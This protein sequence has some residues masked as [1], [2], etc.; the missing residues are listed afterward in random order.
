MRQILR[1]FPPLEI[2]QRLSRLLGR[3]LPNHAAV[4][5]RLRWPLWVLPA[6][7]LVQLAID[8]PVW[9]ITSVAVLLLY[10]SGWLWVR[11]LARSVRLQRTRQGTLFVAGDTLEEQWQI[12][13]DGNVPVSWAECVDES[14]LPG[15]APGRV[16]AV[17][18]NATQKWRTT[19]LCRE[20]GVFRLGPHRLHLAD[21]MRLFDLSLEFPYSESVLI[22]PR[23]VQLP[24]FPLPRGY[25]SGDQRTR[26]PLLGVLPAPTVRTYQP[27]DSLR[28]VHWPT[29]AHRG[30]L[31]VRELEQEPSGAIWVILDTAG[32]AHSREGDHSTLEVAITAAASLAAQF[33]D[34]SR[35]AV[36]I[37]T[38]SGSEG[39]AVTVAPA[40]GSAHLWRILSALAPVRAG[41]TPLDQI[42]RAA[43]ATTGARSSLVV[44]TAD[45]A[46]PERVQA[47]NAQLV[48]TAEAGNAAALLLVATNASAAAAARVRSLL[49]PWQIPVEVLPVDTPMTALLTRKRT[50]TI[51]RTT[52]QGRTL[53]LEVEEEVG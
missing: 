3:G 12:I 24:I 26:R 49:A 42:L 15:Y 43:R 1:R 40:A 32:E 48:R 6:G 16:V 50:R 51:L 8:D 2:S 17:G 47:W 41:A 21:P 14:D 39:H 11:V 53:R 13:N 33:L 38:A 9:T 25:S 19:I 28:F 52:P 46:D 34:S 4:T 20:R 30:A 5:L 36:G 23:V 29:T 22:Y 45:L 7:L 44:V 27:D 37:F 35:R 10:L 31:M 18:I